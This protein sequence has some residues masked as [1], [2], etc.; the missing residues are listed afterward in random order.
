MLVTMD[1]PTRLAK[2]FSGADQHALAGLVAGTL[3]PGAFHSTE[4][5]TII[6]AARTNGVAPLLYRTLRQRGVDLQAPEWRRLQAANQQALWGYLRFKAAFVEIAGLLADAN[7]PAIWLK[8]FALAHTIYPNPGSR[9]MRDLDV[10]VP[11]AQ[12]EQARNCLAQIGYTLRD[13]PQSEAMRE[14]WHHYPLKGRI[15]LEVHSSLIG[16]RSKLIGEQEL[17]WF[18]SQ[19]RVIQ[20]HDLA[21]TIFKPEAELLYLSAHAIL[22]HGENE[23]KLQRY[24]DVHLL[25]EKNPHLD[26]T[27]VL[28]RAVKFR[29]TY[30]VARTLEFA[31]DYFG[32]RLDDA[33][34]AALYAQRRADEDPAHAAWIRSDSTS[35]EVAYGLMAGMH[36][37]EKI[38][39]ATGTFFP[40]AN[41]MRR[42]YPM[43]AR[44]KL[45]WLYLSRWSD[46]AR[47]ALRTML[48]WQRR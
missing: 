26:W 14:M 22:Q 39:W 44:R 27:L 3:E 5:A 10:L 47:D 21:F 15:L 35:W 16:P 36:W 18:W 12:R 42:R 25:L 48:K 19:I 45:P 46:M 32:T 38:H 28:E 6:D 43:H 17:A 11:K 41:F 9:P 4:L 30:A 8:G 40:S 1:R 7:I 2:F 34:L 20:H 31:R 37:R 13:V 29:W 23:F 33:W 24:L